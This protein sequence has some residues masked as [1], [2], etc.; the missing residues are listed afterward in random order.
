MSRTK[1][2]KKPKCHL[3]TY[4]PTQQQQNNDLDKQAFT[5]ICLFHPTCTD[6]HSGLICIYNCK[7]EYLAQCPPLLI[8]K[9]QT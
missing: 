9:R 1:Y 7:Q 8:A 4:F 2:L 6:T 5:V 3:L